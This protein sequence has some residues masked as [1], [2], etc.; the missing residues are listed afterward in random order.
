MGVHVAVV[1]VFLAVAPAVHTEVGVGAKDAER[2]EHHVER[3][4]VVRERELVHGEVVVVAGAPVQNVA[5]QLDAGE[6]IVEA[7]VGAV[8]GV[9]HVVHAAAVFVLHVEDFP[10]K[11]FGL[12][13]VAVG[14]A[15]GVAFGID[16]GVEV[17]V[18][19]VGVAPQVEP[20]VERGP[21]G[22]VQR[23]AAAVVDAEN[24]GCCD[25][26]G[27]FWVRFSIA[28]RVGVRPEGN[29]RLFAVVTEFFTEV[30][31]APRVGKE[32]AALPHG[33]GVVFQEH[34]GVVELAEV[35]GVF[36]PYNG[37][38]GLGAYGAPEH[39][40]QKGSSAESESFLQGAPRVKAQNRS[41]M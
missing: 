6:G 21:D 15:R 36:G 12:A 29:E 8:T 22:I 10:V 26:E 41:I 5:G 32:L 31:V 7:E 4:H 24:R 30:Q 19:G 27:V 38:C 25:D 18:E 20:A 11:A 39:R 34:G 14:T 17:E 3:D 1:Q 33:L 13:L 35:S 40:N 16:A 9:A 28:R 37:G 23:F 2:A